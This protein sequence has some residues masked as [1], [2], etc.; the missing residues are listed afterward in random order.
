[1]RREPTLAAVADESATPKPD[2]P[3]P[4]PD[5]KL[6]AP[7]ETTGEA[8]ATFKAKFHTTKGEFVIAAHRDWSPKGVDRFH[9]LVKLGF[10]SDI[11]F[12]RAVD[13]FVAQFGIHG[14]PKVS[15]AWQKANIADEPVKEGNKRGRIVFAKAGPNTRTT[16]FF[17]NLGDNK[18]L[19]AMGFPA[20]GEIVEG[21]AVVDSLYKGYGEA[22]S[23][24]QGTI[25]AKGNAFLRQNF[26]KLDYITSA[27]IMP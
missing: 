22:P 6:L 12:F 17:L 16:Q 24:H 1:M 19:D 14:H 20:I 15:A 13:G 4:E 3:L 5:P 7:N 21:M 18:N 10:F 25:S 11:A 26:P 2:A 23:G 27:E 9:Q 8:P